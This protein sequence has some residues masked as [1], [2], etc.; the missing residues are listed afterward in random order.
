MK[1]KIPAEYKNA[2]EVLG[3]VMPEKGET[4]SVTGAVLHRLKKL[5]FKEVRATK[6]AK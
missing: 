6:E 1:L 4:V 3:V 5:G 2:V